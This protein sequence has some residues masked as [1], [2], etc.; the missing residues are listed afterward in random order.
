MSAVT[1]DN[2]DLYTAWPK[3]F[4]F[5]LKPFQLLD[6]IIMCSVCVCMCVLCVCVCVCVCVCIC[7]RYIDGRDD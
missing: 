6:H 2:S 7:C 1:Q 4:P 3:T 5:R